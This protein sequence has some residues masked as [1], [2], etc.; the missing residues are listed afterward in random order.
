MDDGIFLHGYHRELIL[1]LIVPV[2]R[3][4]V[5]ELD[6]ASH[7]LGRPTIVSGLG[8]TGSQAQLHTGEY[9]QVL[10]MFR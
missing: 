6:S 10:L 9:S 4:T 3:S 7:E 5:L 2:R 8:Y 1:L